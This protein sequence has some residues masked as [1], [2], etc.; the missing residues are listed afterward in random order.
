MPTRDKA[1]LADPTITMERQFRRIRILRGMQGRDLHQAVFDRDLWADIKAEAM[2]GQD[3]SLISLDAVEAIERAQRKRLAEGS[4]GVFFSSD[5]VIIVPCFLGSQLVDVSGDRGQIWIDPRA[6]KGDSEAFTD[7]KLGPYEP[8]EPE[9]DAG[10]ITIRPDGGLPLIYDGLKFDLEERRYS[11]RTFGFDWRKDLETSA[12]ALARLI[13]DREDLRF[14]PLHLIAHAQGSLVARRAI[15]LLG[16][17]LAPRL[18]K[19]LVLLGPATAGSFL[20]FTA[21]SGNYK[22]MELTQRLGLEPPDEFEKTFQTFSGL[23][24]LIP[25]R[26][27]PIGHREMSKK[28]TRPMKWLEEKS[29]KIKTPDFW[30]RGIDMDRLEAF[31]GWGEK[32]ETGFFNDR[33]T[34]ILGDKP[35][36]GGVKIEG[37]RFVE[38]TRYQT[39]G[40]GKIPD[41]L[42]LVEGVSRVY[43]AA[44][45]GHRTLPTS[46]AVIAA[47]RDILADR[48]PRVAAYRPSSSGGPEDPFPVLAVPDV[49]KDVESLKPIRRELILAPRKAGE[50]SPPQHRRLRV[51]SFDPLMATELDAL[52]TEQITLELPWD[53]AD[54][55]LLQPGPVGEYVEVIDCDP[56]SGCVYPPI[57]LNHPHILAQDGIPVSEGDPRF[58]QQ[59]VYAVAMNTIRQF[60]RALGRKALWSPHLARDA[61]GTVIPCPPSM[62]FEQQAEREFVQRLR[63]YPHAMKQANA[64]YHPEKKALLFGYF[65]A[66][67][68]EGDRNLPGGTVFTCLSHDVVAHETTHALLDGMHRYFVEPSNGD[69]FAFHEAFADIVA[70]FQHF[71]HRE[72]L[73]KELAQA[74][75]DV[76]H[77]S[78]LGILAAQFGEATGHRGAL[79]QYLGKKDPK[80]GR[81]LA[82]EPDTSAIARVTEPH[83]R[84]ALLVAALFRAFT[85][86]YENRVKDLRRIA[87]NGTGLLP[88]GELHP[89]LVARMADEA[90]RSADHMLTM[91]IRALD[92]VPPVDIS[93]GEYL[94]ALITADQ[95]L[96]PEDTRHYRVSIVSAFRDWG[97]YPSDVRSLSVD[98]LLWAEPEIGVHPD[99]REF[100]EAIKA[101]DWDLTSD[102]RRAYERMKANAMAFHEWLVKGSTVTIKEVESMGICYN[103]ETAPLSIRRDK[104]SN[105]P[106]FEVHA[107]R[108]CRR[109]GPDRQQRTEF[110][111]E[112]VQKRR[113]FFDEQTQAGMDEGRI[114]FD[115]KESDF[116]FR[117]GCTLLIDPREGRIRYCVRKPIRDNARLARER[118]FRLG[119]AGD[120]VG[121]IYIDGGG[122]RRNPF[123][124]LHGGH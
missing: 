69:V 52:G 15:Q 54:G 46:L 70:L 55:N 86:I 79:R 62:P 110:V 11:V 100:L 118:Q 104:E 4:L 72:V 34:I 7:L 38:D 59:M 23:Y 21:L 76:S 12:V 107:F 51:F 28:L 92:Y 49:H 10:D 121:G 64:Y 94:R 93:F 65:P 17:D 102:R 44:K 77:E 91:C 18:V 22:T 61:H 90:A 42:A 83:E 95:D 58:H 114:P 30:P 31:F 98:N 13:K 35:T 60:E 85:N 63:I 89:D 40:D 1:P 39:S 116:V 88:D 82:I 26:V 43:K 57:D 47:V 20:A 96:V 41:A 37:G 25:W 122:R 45:T 68:Q 2:A 99:L 105:N 29:K 108:P 71:S 119:A 106:V 124:F 16:A 5:D 14:R 74:R 6:L 103:H 3:D 19:S 75:G 84:G 32:I 78:K 27:K 73:L 111:V 87:T 115:S 66:E 53:F 117:G 36:V 24:Q 113:A 109:I 97:I 33:T 123:A 81:W 48:P 8:D 9:K 101:Q 112:I 67:G 120:G 56:A 50:V 80:T